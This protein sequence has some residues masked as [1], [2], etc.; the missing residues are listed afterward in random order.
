MLEQDRTEKYTQQEIMDLAMYL[1]K[2]HKNY[3]H[4]DIIGVRLETTQ[5]IDAAHVTATEL[6]KYTAESRWYRVQNYL[7][8][9]KYKLDE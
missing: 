2:L 7:D 8:Q 4:P 6:A 9:L 5:A 1:V 3:K